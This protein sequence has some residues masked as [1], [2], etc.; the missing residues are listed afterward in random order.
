[1]ARKESP[2][3]KRSRR[4]V[5]PAKRRTRKRSAPR[6]AT[7]ALFEPSAFPTEGALDELYANL[8]T[9]PNV[10]GCYIGP[11]TKRNH[12]LGK[13]AV[14]CCVANKVGNKELDPADRIPRRLKWPRTRSKQFNLVTDVQP[15]GDSELQQSAPVV[16]PGDALSLS[17]VSSPATVGLA[18]KLPG[19]HTVIT[20]AGHAFI[21]SSAGSTTFPAGT[22][23]VQINNIGP[24]AGAVSFSAT[25][26]KA[27]RSEDVDYALL[28]PLAEPR[29]LFQ[30]ALNISS[31]F[32][33]RP[34][35]VDKVDLFALTQRGAL[36]TRLRGVLGT[37]TM[38]GISMRG[39]L[40]TDPVTAGGDSGCCLVDGRFRVW[41]LLVGKKDVNGGVVSVFAAANLVLA[42]ENA[43]LA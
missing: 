37:L 22:P 25:P 30:D 2:R 43:R 39:L 20:T 5:S 14:V 11:K 24:G 10:E 12:R 34:E 8:M 4:S 16:G 17:A 29:N 6:K 35:D 26:L 1:V 41:G 28:Q 19:G 38:G 13:L 31:V 36:P 7:A 21:G 40:L 23:A 33:A 27:V 32:I 42:F 15:V 9:L 18:L 3:S